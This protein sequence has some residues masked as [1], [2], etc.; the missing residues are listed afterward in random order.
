MNLNI[1]KWKTFLLSDVFIIKY[2]VNLELN[3]CDESVEKNSINFVSR[4]ESN[5]GVSA[6]VLPIQGVEPQ[7]EGLITV[8]AGGSV[9][10]TFVQPKPFY[11]GRDLYTL[12]VKENI[13]IE[14]KLFLTTLICKNKYKYNYGRQANK[15]LSLIKLKLPIRQ[16]ES[17][18]PIIDECKKYSKEGYIPDWQFME[19][20]IK[21]LHYKPLTTKNRTYNN[22][23]LRR[24]EWV[25]FELNKLFTIQ[26]AYAY[27]KETLPPTNENN[28][29]LISCIT[30]TSF[31]NGCDYMAEKTQELKIERGNALTVGGEGRF[32]FYQNQ[33]F[34]CGTNMSVLRSAELNKYTGLFIATV[35]N[36]EIFKYSYGRARSKKQ[37][38]KEKIK[39]PVKKNEDGMIYL[40]NTREFSEKGYVPD[41][42]FMED[43]IKS[44]PYG[45]KIS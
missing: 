37:L 17:G 40:D 23:S 38:C 20:Y 41:W 14:S 16:D 24:D 29:D 3:T 39:L 34:V 27:N 36:K 5:N 9:L 30:R 28:I 13:S 1:E 2:G 15:T 11:S 10:S 6:K 25:F 32:C 42:Q 8:A 35:M 26:K 45:D 19:D 21:S 44:L 7:K 18:V 4:T 43:Y 22:N 12:E 33:D 31:N